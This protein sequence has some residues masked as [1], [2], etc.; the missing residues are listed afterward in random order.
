MKTSNIS[1]KTNSQRLSSKYRTLFLNL[2]MRHRKI[3]IKDEIKAQELCWHAGDAVTYRL[4]NENLRGLRQCRSE[5][6]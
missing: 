2:P 1:S 3:F 6:V 5:R 4:M